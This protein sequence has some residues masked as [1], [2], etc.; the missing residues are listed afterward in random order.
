M[1]GR[2]SAAAGAQA[3]HD[4]RSGVRRARVVEPDAA[5]H[6]QRAQLAELQ[7]QIGIQLVGIRPR[8]DVGVSGQL[9][10]EPARGNTELRAQTE[11]IRLEVVAGA[12][13]QLGRL[14]DADE[15]TPPP[16]CLGVA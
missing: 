8:R 11:V 12:H 2:A 14:P 10:D 13:A 7:H 3:H 1:N 9:Q 6:I 5:T 15:A 4:V 16:L